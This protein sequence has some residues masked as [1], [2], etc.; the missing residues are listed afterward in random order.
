MNL[1]A[2][3]AGY[4]VEAVDGIVVEVRKRLYTPVK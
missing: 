3:M 4:G 1:E 2:L